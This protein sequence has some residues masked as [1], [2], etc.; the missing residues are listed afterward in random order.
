MSD[1]QTTEISF[2]DT[3]MSLSD[4]VEIKDQ[5]GISGH[6][7]GCGLWAYGMMSTVED[8]GI[9]IYASVDGKDLSDDRLVDALKFSSDINILQ[10]I[11]EG[12]V[13]NYKS[14]IDVLPEVYL[15]TWV[16]SYD[17]CVAVQ[18]VNPEGDCTVQHVRAH[19]GYFR[20]ERVF[21]NNL[22]EDY[23]FKEG[24]SFYEDISGYVTRIGIL[25]F[26]EPTEDDVGEERLV[27]DI[28]YGISGVEYERFDALMM[29]YMVENFKI[30][31]YESEY[32]IYDDIKNGASFEP[33]YIEWLYWKSF[34][35]PFEH[36][37]VP[38]Q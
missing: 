20:G 30:D 21:G 29:K 38:S 22:L 32:V 10:H 5:A 28:M 4:E 3:L 36:L 19:S 14:L 24:E 15:I 7:L 34:S 2:A 33:R 27:I 26:E 11:K 35:F 6:Y 23:G 1:I 37:T 17:G 13:K 25:K 9:F 18:S 8:E 31:A 16:W 12:T